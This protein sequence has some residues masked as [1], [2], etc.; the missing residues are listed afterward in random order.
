M[1][2]YI[3][4]NTPGALAELNEPLKYMTAFYVPT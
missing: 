1:I 2:Y 3:K 4:I